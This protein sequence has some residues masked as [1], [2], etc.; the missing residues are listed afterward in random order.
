MLT[1]Q[2]SQSDFLD[3]SRRIHKGFIPQYLALINY[4]FDINIRLSLCQNA[5]AYGFNSEG[6][7][8]YHELNKLYTNKKYIK[9]NLSSC[10]DIF[11]RFIDEINNHI[12]EKS[13]LLTYKASEIE[14]YRIFEMIIHGKNLG[15]KKLMLS[16]WA[17]E[18]N[19]PNNGNITSS[20]NPTEREVIENLQIQSSLNCYYRYS[21]IHNFVES[22]VYYPNSGATI[23]SA[24]SHEYSQFKNYDTV[25]MIASQRLAQLIFNIVNYDLWDFNK[26]GNNMDNP[27]NNRQLLLASLYNLTTYEGFCSVYVRC[28]DSYPFASPN[29]K[30][31]KDDYII[32]CYDYFYHTLTN[33]TF[34]KYIALI[35]ELI[36]QLI[37]K[38]NNLN[39]TI[40]SHSVTDLD[41]LSWFNNTNLLNNLN[42]NKSDSSY[43]ISLLDLLRMLDMG[44]FGS[45]QVEIAK[46][47]YKCLR[48]K[49]H[50]DKNVPNIENIPTYIC[51][52]NN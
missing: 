3:L 50:V 29:T 36:F 5:L 30:P 31:I 40:L 11:R 46:L 45:Q 34:N 10:V 39:Y 21:L 33:Q 9:F 7:R 23:I 8:D 47:I 44:S 32:K 6:V 17:G 43:N 19:D 25:D 13:G 42:K 51:K 24:I 4:P 15:D 27:T 14:V 26:S 1:Q 41:Y 35:N 18:E 20:Q 16:W 49:S 48:H 28:L 2:I 12:K 22:F 37:N 52:Y 38:T